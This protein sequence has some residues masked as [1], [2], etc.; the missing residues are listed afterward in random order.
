MTKLERQR[1]N[2][3]MWDLLDKIPLPA[4]GT[5][6]SQ[7]SGFVGHSLDAQNAFDLAHRYLFAMLTTHDED[8][9]SRETCDEIEAKARAWISRREA[10]DW[11]LNGARVKP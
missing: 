7:L 6:S 8:D 3:L 10:E 1:L 9:P 4:S 11:S 5:Q 2:F